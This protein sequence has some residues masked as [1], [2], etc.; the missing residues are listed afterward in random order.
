MDLNGW[1]TL[2][3]KRMKKGSKSGEERGEIGYF[4][5]MD[6]MTGLYFQSL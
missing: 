5:K 4:M 3:M 2:R 6:T 1:I